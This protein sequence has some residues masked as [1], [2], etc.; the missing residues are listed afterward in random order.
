MYSLGIVY[1][2]IQEI[3][4]NIVNMFVLLTETIILYL[5]IVEGCY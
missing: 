3:L 1:N 2:P 5:S 4:S